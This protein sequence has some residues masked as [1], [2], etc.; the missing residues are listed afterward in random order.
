MGT[1]TKIIGRENSE[2]KVFT[3]VPRQFPMAIEDSAYDF[4]HSQEEKGSDFHIS[5]EV[6][7]QAGISDLNKQKIDDKIEAEALIKLKEIEESAYKEAYELGLIEGSEKAY[8]EK[9]D[10]LENRMSHLEQ[11]VE[12]IHVLRQKLVEKNEGQLVRMV[13]LLAGRIAER[14]IKE[15]PDSILPVINMVL[16]EI[17]KDEEV[18][19]HLSIADNMFI[20]SLLEKGEKKYE[21][22]RN[23]K[24][25]VDDHVQEGGCLLETRYGVI[26]AT[27]PQRLEKAW[28]I[29][30][31]KIPHVKVHDF[32]Q[33]ALIDGELE[34]GDASVGDQIDSKDEGES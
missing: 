33:G 7:Q 9:R 3:Y 31:S 2:E 18:T 19:L 4:V 26:D 10:E 8:Q 11:L 12:T 1:L 16:E 14:E 5:A 32:Q 23:I 17:Q 34:V 27:L 24:I 22:L 15:N 25:E 20:E 29:L 30:Q 6:A 21:F 28:N 13:Y